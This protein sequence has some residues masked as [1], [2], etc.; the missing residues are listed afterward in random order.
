MSKYGK[1]LISTNE[2]TYEL[3][4]KSFFKRERPLFYRMNSNMRGVGVVFNRVVEGIEFINCNFES[5]NKQNKTYLN[6]NSHCPIIITNSKVAHELDIKLS[7]GPSHNVEMKNIKPKDNVTI[8]VE[9]ANTISLNE[10]ENLSLELTAFEINITNAKF[11]TNTNSII[12]L[13]DKISLKNII[14]DSL[15]EIR[16]T[17]QKSLGWINTKLVS[18]NFYISD[19][20]NSHN[21]KDTDTTYIIDDEAHKKLVIQSK[22]HSILKGLKKIVDTKEK[23]ILDKKQE[24]FKVTT[25]IKIENL[26]KQI[27]TLEESKELIIEQIKDGMESRKINEYVKK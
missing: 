19:L 7:V 18:S 25:D 12:L 15:N 13:A 20:F 22:L 2:E 8:V 5:L 9:D 4:E 16:I 23:E 27:K 6:I 11:D 1:V 10:V 14:S 24:E 26:R 3:N 21:R 17:A